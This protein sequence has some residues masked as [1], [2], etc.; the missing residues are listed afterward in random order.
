MHLEISGYAF[1]FV[2]QFVAGFVSQHGPQLRR[3]GKAYKD[4]ERRKLNMISTQ[5]PQALR[6]SRM[7]VT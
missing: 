4:D 2:E 6:D 5:M 3:A 1:V 7:P